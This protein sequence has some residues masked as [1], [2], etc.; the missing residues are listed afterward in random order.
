MTEERSWGNVALADG[1]ELEDHQQFAP[2]GCITWG[3]SDSVNPS[4]DGIENNQAKMESYE[5]LRFVSN[6]GKEQKVSAM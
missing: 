1:N 5:G 3:I 4:N 6:S 2:N